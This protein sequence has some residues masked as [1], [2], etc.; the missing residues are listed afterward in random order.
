VIRVSGFGLRVQGFGVR[1]CGWSYHVKRFRG[2]LVFKAQRLMYHS[3]LGLRVIKKKK[4]QTRRT[5]AKR[6][7][8]RKGSARGDAR[9][10]V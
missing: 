6:E 8:R 1:D 7:A 4:Y 3:T 10:W 2:G 9:N 5:A